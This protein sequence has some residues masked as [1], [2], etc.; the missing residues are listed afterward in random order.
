M[1]ALS[2]ITRFSTIFKKRL[3]AL[4]IS[5]FLQVEMPIDKAIDTLMRL[6]LATETSIDG[7]KGLRAVPCPKAYEGLKE[8]WNSLLK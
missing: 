2:S 5:G 4:L 6:G 1:N 8:R 7:S 3:L